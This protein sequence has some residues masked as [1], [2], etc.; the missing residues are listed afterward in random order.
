VRVVQQAIADRIGLVGIAD[1]PV[2]VLDGR[3]AYVRLTRDPNSS[4]LRV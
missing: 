3:L 2:P 4:D 1:D